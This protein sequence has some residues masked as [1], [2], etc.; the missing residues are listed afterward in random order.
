MEKRS[1]GLASFFNALILI[2]ILGLCTLI[3][4]GFFRLG[5]S[6]DNIITVYIIG[7]LVAS[8]VASK[9]IYGL[10]ASIIGVSLYIWC[11]AQPLFTFPSRYP[12]YILTLIMLLAASIITSI[13]STQ[14]RRR[15]RAETASHPETSEPAGGLSTRILRTI[16]F[17]A[18]VYHSTV[19]PTV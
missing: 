19:Q 15:E 9:L 10:F 8:F 1:P 3:A 14:Y 18:T 12:Q 13:I 7:I 11:F 16:S 17:S 2:S 5:F 4:Y 6:E